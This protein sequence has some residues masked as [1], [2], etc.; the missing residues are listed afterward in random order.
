MAGW[1]F[2]GLLLMLLGQAVRG[3]VHSAAAMPAVAR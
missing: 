1:L 2:V 3:R